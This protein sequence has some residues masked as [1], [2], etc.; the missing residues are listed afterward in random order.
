MGGTLEWIPGQHAR[1]AVPLGRLLGIFID[2]LCR[3]ALKRVG[4]GLGRVAVDAGL[5]LAVD[6]RGDWGEFGVVGVVD[7][8]DA[9][10]LLELVYGE[11]R[12]SGRRDRGPFRTRWLGGIHEWERKRRETRH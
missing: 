10:L 3:D 5:G 4:S 12:A 6:E 11:R 9:M 2:N 1:V 7:G 8:L